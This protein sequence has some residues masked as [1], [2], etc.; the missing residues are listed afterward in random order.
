MNFAR[1]AWGVR[2][3][4]A[5]LFS[6]AVGLVQLG[7]QTEP[8]ANEKPFAVSAIVLADHPVNQCVPTQALGAGVDGHEQG[9]YARMFP[10]K[11]IAVMPP[12]PCRR[13]THRS[14]T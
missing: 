11:I 5:S 7:S 12:A 1:R 2:C 9:E 6:L 3:V 8:H 4:L 14:R 10:E 13:V